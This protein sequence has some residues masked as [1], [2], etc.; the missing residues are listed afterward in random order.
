MVALSLYKGHKI[1]NSNTPYTTTT[2]HTTHTV[3][4]LFLRSFVGSAESQRHHYSHY[5][6]KAS[7]PLWLRLHSAAD[8]VELA[9]CIQLAHGVVDVPA[10]ALCCFTNLLCS[11][12][13]VR[14]EVVPYGST[15]T[16]RG[17]TFHAVLFFACWLGCCCGHWLLKNDPFAG[18]QFG[19]LHFKSLGVVL[20]MNA[21]GCCLG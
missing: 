19:L 16:A 1:K 17:W 18:T 13:G 3:K 8:S 10:F 15:E 7:F 9:P 14:V 21:A 5:R 2:T 4:A 20:P 11:C 12:A 6:R